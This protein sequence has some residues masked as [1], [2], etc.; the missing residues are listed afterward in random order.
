MF[1]LYIQ[2][3]TPKMDD[4]EDPYPAAHRLEQQRR[5]RTN[6]ERA[7]LRNRRHNIEKFEDL[8]N[9]VVLNS[10][11]I[12]RAYPPSVDIVETV[13]DVPASRLT[14]RN[15]PVVPKDYIKTA[16][17]L[18]EKLENE[19]SPPGS[20]GPTTFLLQNFIREYGQFVCR[21]LRY[22]E[23]VKVSKNT[24]L[25]YKLCRSFRYMELYANHGLPIL[26]ARVNSYLGTE[27]NFNERQHN[28][29]PGERKQAILL[30]LHGEHKG[31]RNVPF[32]PWEFTIML[33]R[34]TLLC[35]ST[36]RLIEI[37]ENILS[38]YEKQR[39]QLFPYGDEDGGYDEEDE[40]D[41]EDDVDYNSGADEEEEDEEDL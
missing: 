27:V 4:W 36:S 38:Y 7:Q 2:T 6:D 22:L 41:E 39:S 33:P 40:E 1:L 32:H 9:A 20:Y 23:G 35:V 14:V 19:H 13:E 5:Q 25:N 12:S 31:K 21:Y 26:Q 28:M 8:P 29:T 34:K 24:Y 16:K 10:K 18:V 15:P 11:K 3:A 30:Y 17:Y 37:G